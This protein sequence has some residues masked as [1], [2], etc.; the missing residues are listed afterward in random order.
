M[1]DE[2]A[3]TPHRLI[4]GLL[5]SPDVSL[6]QVLDDLTGC[7]G[8]LLEQSDQHRFTYTDYYNQEMSGEPY[9][10]YLCFSRLVD[11]S[12]LAAIK[13]QTNKLEDHYRKDG[14]R[15]VNLDPGTLSL[16]NV[17]L[18]TT[19]GRAHRIPL[20]QGIYAELTLLYANKSYQCFP[21]TYQDYASK[22]VQ[23]LLLQWREQYKKQLKQEGYL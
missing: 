23:T 15:R 7:F 3:F 11:P 14:G 9:R 16:A 19:K 6:D 22:K 5:I 4:L 2:H 17:I 18:A 1:A 10:S 8:P 20:S 12:T 21:W 13:Q